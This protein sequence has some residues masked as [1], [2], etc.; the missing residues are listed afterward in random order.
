MV[1]KFEQYKA[2]SDNHLE[3]LFTSSFFYIQRYWN[4][5]ALFFMT[6]YPLF[7][8][9]PHVNG[10]FYFAISC[11][12]KKKFWKF[13]NS[14]TVNILMTFYW[15]FCIWISV[16]SFEIMIM[17]IF[18]ALYIFNFSLYWTCTSRDQQLYQGLPQ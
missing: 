10:M 11:T 16:T 1:E 4:V 7:C 12:W 18:V 9:W 15:R 3:L 5:Y 2:C 13:Q 17:Y 14:R 8:M 6:S